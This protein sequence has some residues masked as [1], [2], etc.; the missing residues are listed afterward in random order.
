M[1]NKNKS[2][3]SSY[4]SNN[5]DLKMSE[6]LSEDHKMFKNKQMKRNE[7]YKLDEVSKNESSYSSQI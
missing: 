5:Y 7:L 4:Y 1:Q 3:L 2:I 6:N